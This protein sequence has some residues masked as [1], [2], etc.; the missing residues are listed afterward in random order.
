MCELG[1]DCSS[2]VDDGE[3]RKQV[4]D[5]GILVADGVGDSAG[6]VLSVG[7]WMGCEE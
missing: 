3:D 7:V 2:V 1:G 6:G 5:G 4:G